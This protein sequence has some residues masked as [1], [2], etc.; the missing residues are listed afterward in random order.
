MNG[1]RCYKHG[2]PTGRCSYEARYVQQ[3]PS[4]HIHSSVRWRGVPL[5]TRTSERTL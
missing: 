5:R 1:I 4:P 3:A 2:T